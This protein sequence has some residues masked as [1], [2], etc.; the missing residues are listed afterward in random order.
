MELNWIDS[1]ELFCFVY[2]N[3]APWCR[4]N[5]EKVF[6][7]LSRAPFASKVSFC[8]V[9]KIHL[10]VCSF[11]AFEWKI[12]LALL[13]AAPFKITAAYTAR[14]HLLIIHMTLSFLVVVFSLVRFFFRRS[15][16]VQD[17]ATAAEVAA[18]ASAQYNSSP[19]AL[20]LSSFFSKFSSL[21]MI[22]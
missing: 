13:S 19:F 18:I 12:A 14:P 15:R 17:I 5:N 8:G 9:G 2:T 22:Y 21:F 1:F 7:S 4:I 20:T 11:L 3:T 16:F 6:L 10:F